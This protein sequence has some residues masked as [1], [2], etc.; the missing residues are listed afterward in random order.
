MSYKGRD[1]KQSI[2]RKMAKVGG[3]TKDVV[4]IF[5]DRKI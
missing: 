3:F 4:G 5:V 2:K 1:T